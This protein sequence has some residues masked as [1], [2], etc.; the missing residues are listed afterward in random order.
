MSFQGITPTRGE[1]DQLMEIEGAK[2]VGTKVS[3]PL[4]LNQEVY[5]LPMEN[6]LA[7]KVRAIFFFLVYLIAT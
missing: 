4:A 7:T 5:V 1:A 2:I 3:A 6:V